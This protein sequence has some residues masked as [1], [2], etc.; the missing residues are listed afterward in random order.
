MDEDVEQPWRGYSPGRCSQMMFSTRCA[1]AQLCVLFRSIARNS[2][3]NVA[4]PVLR[5]QLGTAWNSGTTQPGKP[6][7]F[8]S[9]CLCS[10]LSSDRLPCAFPPVSPSASQVTQPVQPIQSFLPSLSQRVQ[11]AVPFIGGPSDDE[12]LGNGRVDPLTLLL[13]TPCPH[14]SF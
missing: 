6:R 1:I 3:A 12:A 7:Y 9:L 4:F 5:E 14:M 10:R 2:T 13:A 11:D 8:P